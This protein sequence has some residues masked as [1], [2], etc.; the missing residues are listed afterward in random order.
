[1]NPR[2]AVPR[3][4]AGNPES[5][6]RAPVRVIGTW[7]KKRPGPSFEEPGHKPG[8]DL[9]SRDLTSYYHQLLGA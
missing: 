9:L 6:L 4:T 2:G 1:M 7:E 8:N 3:T 5:S